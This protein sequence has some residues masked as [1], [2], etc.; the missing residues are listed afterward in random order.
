MI[1]PH[2]WTKSIPHGHTGELNEIKRAVEDSE[3]PA[4]TDRR[5]QNRTQPKTKLTK[6]NPRPQSSQQ[7][8]YQIH[9][10]LS[11]GHGGPCWHRLLLTWNEIN[12]TPREHEVVLTPRRYFLSMSWQS[13][14]VEVSALFLWYGCVIL[15]EEILFERGCCRACR[16]PREMEKCSL[17][18][19]ARSSLSLYLKYTWTWLF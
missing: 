6:P 19:P 9:S 3:S 13:I 16:A 18:F 10:N 17:V 7:H 1:E 4:V 2:Y 14:D 8:G 12:W 5:N 11:E 15:S